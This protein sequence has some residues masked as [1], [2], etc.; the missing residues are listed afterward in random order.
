MIFF[1]RCHYLHSIKLVAFACIYN[2]VQGRVLEKV[3]TKVNCEV[4]LTQ[5]DP[6]SLYV[7]LSRCS[8]LDGIM[9]LSKAREM[10]FIGNTI[11]QNMVAAEQ[12][13]EELYERTIREA[14]PWEWS[15]AR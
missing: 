6:Y 3:V 4:G 14:E 10:D 1:R 13:L 15:S 12:R 11:P 5:C 9:L 8:L 7:Q 2:K